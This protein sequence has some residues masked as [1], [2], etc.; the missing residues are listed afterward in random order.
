MAAGG[1]GCG[2][3]GGMIIRSSAM[4]MMRGGEEK[5]LRTSLEGINGR[6]P[7]RKALHTAA[8]RYGRRYTRRPVAISKGRCIR[9]P[10]DTDGGIYGRPQ[11]RTAVYTAARKHGRRYIR[12]PS[13]QEVGLLHGASDEYELPIVSK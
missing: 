11:I 8:R 5:D 1:G 2:G 12:P 4:M 10:A 3:G 7:I 13:S 9:P 6:P